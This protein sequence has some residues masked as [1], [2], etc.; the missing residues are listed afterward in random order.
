MC[1][2]VAIY[3]VDGLRPEIACQVGVRFFEMMALEVGSAGYYRR[4]AKPKN[5]DIDFIE[6]SLAGLQEKIRA[7]EVSDF[8]LYQ[9]SPTG[10]YWT[11]SFGFSTKD[12][13]SF[14][15]FDAQ[16]A[17]PGM[18][19]ACV[20][21]IKALVGLA[22][23]SYAIVYQTKNAGD[24]FHYAG[25]HNFLNIFKSENSSLFAHETD[26]RHEGK[27]RYH[28]SML[29]MVYAVNAINHLHLQIPVGNI[30]LREWI[31]QDA[32]RGTLEPLGKDVWLWQVQDEA[33]DAVNQALGE[34]GGLISWKPV[35]AKR[36]SRFLP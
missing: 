3:G 21:F 15:H 7:G 29:R 10:R 16:C 32:Q 13:G 2:A 17:L 36:T 4:R 12:F 18:T 9:D 23:F 30:C 31:V 14:Y 26:G 34:A 6:T 19:E 11:A 28:G 8:R 35:P 24:G 33:L 27:A 5:E 1:I 22:D 20:A 25:G